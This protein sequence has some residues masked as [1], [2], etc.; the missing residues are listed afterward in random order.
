MI[1]SHKVFAC[2][3]QTFAMLPSKAVAAALSRGAKAYTL[4]RPRKTWMSPWPGEN[5][6]SKDCRLSKVEYRWNCPSW[7]RT[8]RMSLSE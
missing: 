1:V 4:N 3:S 6:S 8:L 2:S 7:M 5:A